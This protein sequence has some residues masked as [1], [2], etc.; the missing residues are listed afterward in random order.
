VA[1]LKE[2][3]GGAYTRLIK[4]KPEAAKELEKHLD[5]HR[6][7]AFIGWCEH[8]DTVRG[9]G[10]VVEIVKRGKSMRDML[11]KLIKAKYKCPQCGWPYPGGKE[12]VE[13]VEG[14]FLCGYSKSAVPIE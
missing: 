11:T 3:E 10:Q 14:C 12:E 2:G 1:S 13:K 4:P 5:R 9:K 8:C 7:V 6:V